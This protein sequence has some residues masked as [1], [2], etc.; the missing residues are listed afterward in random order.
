MLKLNG[1]AGAAAGAAG[2]AG[3]AVCAKAALEKTSAADMAIWMGFNFM[4][5]SGELL[6]LNDVAIQANIV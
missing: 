6:K 2:A 4:G 3:A 1:D 5:C